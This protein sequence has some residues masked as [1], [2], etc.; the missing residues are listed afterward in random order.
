M[1]EL[2]A[3]QQL[4]NEEKQQI[5]SLAADG[6]SDYRIGKAVNRSP[7]TVKAFLSKPEVVKDVQSEKSELAVLYQQKAHEIVASISD[8]DIAAASLQQKAISSGVLLDKSLLLSGQPTGINIQVLLDVAALIRRGSDEP[9][10]LPA[11]P[12]GQQ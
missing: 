7:H 1:K 12:E 11:L 10:T 4:T 9:P 2:P 6:W 3:R 8:S 5:T